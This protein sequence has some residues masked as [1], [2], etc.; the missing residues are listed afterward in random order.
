M[1]KLNKIKKFYKSIKRKWLKPL[2]YTILSS[3]MIYLI[4]G[5]LIVR[6]YNFSSSKPHFVISTT[7]EKFEYTEF[8]HMLLTIQEINTTVLKEDLKTFVNS[9]FPAK[10]PKYLKQQLHN[11][12]WE[13]NA[14]Q[15]RAQ[16]L[17]KMYDI[18]DQIVRLE[19]TIEMF[20]QESK[21]SIQAP[22][23][24][25]QIRSLKTEKERIIK[26]NLTPEEY[27]FIQEYGGVVPSLQLIEEK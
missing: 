12:N 7:S 16:K 5:N 10:C 22:I 6:Q 4:I 1:I 19:S 26:E 24:F 2:A 3:I 14:F 9:P 20:N 17:I 27:E 25:E 8:M 11:M 21:T 23:L 18:Y 13:A 15:I